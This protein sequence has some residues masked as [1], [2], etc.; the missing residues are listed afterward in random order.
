MRTYADEL[1]ERCDAFWKA[2]SGVVVYRR[3]R[4]A[5]CFSYGCRDMKSSLENQLGALTMSMRYK[6]DVPN[7]LEPWYGIGTI[8]SAYELDYIWSKGQA[9]AIKAPFNS[10]DEVLERVPVAVEDTQIGAHTLEM[11]LG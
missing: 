8:A 3:M 2:D 4:V 6:A 7:F 1:N 9:P 5:D 10:L 11:I